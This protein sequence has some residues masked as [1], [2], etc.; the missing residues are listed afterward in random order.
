M[1]KNKRQSLR[2][3]VE[4]LGK[5]SDIVDDVLQD[6]EYCLDNMPENLQ[7]SERFENM[8]SAID[9]MREAS[10]MISS[11]VEELEEAQS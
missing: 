4:Y 5:A 1:N 3:A 11:A 8:E 9:H 2:S 7:N 6:E 10:D